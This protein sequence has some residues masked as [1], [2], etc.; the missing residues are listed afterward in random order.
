M[1]G[2]NASLR[3]LVLITGATGAIGPRVTEACIS[4]GYVVRTLSMDSGG[5]RS[6]RMRLEARVGDIT[7]AEEIRSAA[8]GV[9]AVIHLAGLLHINDPPAS[10]RSEYERVNIGGIL[11][12]LE[13]ARD[14]GASRVVFFRTIAVYGPAS[15]PGAVV[16]DATHTRPETMYGKRGLRRSDEFSRQNALMATHSELCFASVR[17]MVQESREI[18]SAS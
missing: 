11:N 6:P 5:V 18:T 7:D 10:M 16:D 14:A 4:A 2:C 9:D 13:A 3:K 17:C 15:E 1:E 12:V 8:Q